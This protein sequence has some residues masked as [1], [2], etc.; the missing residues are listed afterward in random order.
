MVECACTLECAKLK[1]FISLPFYLFHRLYLSC[2]SFI[3]QRVS[4]YF[5]PF[6]LSCF[7][8]FWHKT[9]DEQQHEK[10][11]KNPTTTK[12]HT[13]QFNDITIN[14]KFNHSFHQCQHEQLPPSPPPTTKTHFRF[15]F[16]SHSSL[17]QSFPPLAI[18]SRPSL[19]VCA[20]VCAVPELTND[21]DLNN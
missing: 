9:H 7:I 21:G 10:T 5:F 19:C 14:I 12:T 11:S 17:P 8:S 16:S 18:I 15:W 2:F 6:A 3:F 4:C 13:K 20:C 1:N